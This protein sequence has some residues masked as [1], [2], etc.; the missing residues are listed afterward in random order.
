[1]LG[2]AEAVLVA[3]DVVG[4]GVFGGFGEDGARHLSVVVFVAGEPALEGRRAACR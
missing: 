4:G 1:M 2:E 3:F